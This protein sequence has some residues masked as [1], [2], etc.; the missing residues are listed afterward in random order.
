LLAGQSPGLHSISLENPPGCFNPI[1]VTCAAE[2]AE[3]EPWEWNFEIY[4][5]RPEGRVTNQAI[6]AL[7]GNYPNPFNPSTEIRY[8]LPEDAFLTLE[9]FNPLGQRV[10]VLVNEHQ[11]KGVHAVRLDGRSLSSGV[12]FYR[13]ISGSVVAWKRLLLVK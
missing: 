2:D 1:E 10:K 5:E 12:Y 9:V 3:A 4:P 13:L 7:L 6:P 8:A 11:Q